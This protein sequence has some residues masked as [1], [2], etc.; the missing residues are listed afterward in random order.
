MRTI[1]ELLRWRALRH[2]HLP[3]LRDDDRTVSY[4]ELDR[5][6]TLLANG[7][8]HRGIRPGDRV[9]IFDRNSIAYVELLWALAKCGAVAALVNWRLTPRE[10]AQIV[11]DA[12]AVLLVAGD[13][14]ADACAG[15]G[16][17]VI[18]FDALERVDD[19]DPRLDAEEEV[20]W[21]LYTSGTTGVPKGAM[22]THLNLYACMGGLLVEAPDLH[23]GSVAL[24]AMPLF[25]IGGCGWAAAMMFAGTTMVVVRDIVP[26][27]LLR[28]M[29][30]EQVECAFLVPAVLLFLSALPGI[31]QVQLPALRQ[32]FYGASPITPELLERCIR[33]FG[34]AFT[35]VYGLTETTG[36][37]TVLRFLDHR[38]ELLLSCG[39]PNLGTQVRCVDTDGTD[40]APGEIG[41]LLIRSAQVM[42]GYWRREDD[43]AHAIV[44]G[45][46][47]S[48]DAAS[49]DAEGFVFIRDRIK[50]M[51]VSGG[52]NVYPVEVEAALAAHPDVL[53]V[54]VFGVPDERWGETV[55]AAVVR[56]PG[57]SVDEG[58]LLGFV[59]DRLAGYKRPRAIAFVDALPRNATGKVLKRE[60]REPYWA[61]HVRRVAGSG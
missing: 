14:Y 42:A 19:P 32:I 13:D 50:D 28:T 51:V 27:R 48:G 41:E 24:V 35:Q 34:C 10:S 16:V 54:A 33:L 20:V 43:T 44:D 3:A 6:T 15:L 36:A 37:I 58:E 8:L 7:L 18:T 49:I 52:E 38:P 17:P 12:G 53:D 2:P 31:E 29:V 61:G 56:R 30:D 60:L 47:H 26:D 4:A 11:A 46:F 40:V 22:L 45:W 23:E 55:R 9:A 25:H 59:T 5:A 21:Q 57:S 39:R 1:A